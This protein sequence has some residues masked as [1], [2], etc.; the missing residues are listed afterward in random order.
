M[1]GRPRSG[2]DLANRRAAARPNIVVI[3]TD[4]MAASDLKWMPRTRRLIGGNGVRFDNAVANNPLCC[5]A[6]ATL[7]TGQESHNNGVWTNAGPHGGYDRLSRRSRLPQWLQ[8]AGY[9]T[10]MIGKHLNGYEPANDGRD[11]GWDYF[12]PTVGG[13]YRYTDFVSYGNGRPVT[14]RN[15]YIT[16]YVSKASAGVIRR[17]EQQDRK[18]FFLWASYVAPHRSEP[19]RCPVGQLCWDYPIAAKRHRTLFQ[20]ARPPSLGK[21]SFNEADM[22]DKSLPLQ[23]LG[24]V[25]RKV[26][27]RDYRRRIRTLVAVDQAVSRTVGALKRAGELSRTLI[28]FTSDNGYALGEHRWIGKVLPFDESMRVPLLI[29]GPGV[30][31]G[32]TATKLATTA[33]LTATIVD[34]ARSRHSRRL[35]GLSL[36]RY[37]ANPAAVDARPGSLVQSGGFGWWW[38][39]RDWVYRGYREGRYT[40]ARYRDGTLEIYDRTI[41][42]FEIASVADDPA[43]AAVRAE[44][45]RRFR[46]LRDCVGSGCRKNFGPIPEPTP[47]TGSRLPRDSSDVPTEVPTDVP[48]GPRWDAPYVR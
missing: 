30:A 19:A 43:Y 36:K 38:P 46:D 22:S 4:D 42:P 23:L 41:D 26:V 7:L 11:P 17:F 8:R 14:V 33:D 16:D 47:A 3:M 45:L 40:L 10:A 15:G 27:V 2:L 21:P 32:R 24:K 18:P 13:V 5:P 44:L 29:R 6:R 48:T 25:D 34:V 35:D 1:A 37:L 39:Q 12:D 28:V 9:R 31:R 20:K